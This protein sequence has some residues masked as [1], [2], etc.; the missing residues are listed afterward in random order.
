MLYRL[1]IGCL[2]IT[3][4]ATTFGADAFFLCGPDEDGC[5]AEYYSSCLCMP[6]DAQ[7]QH[8]PYCLDF[9]QVAC[10]PLAQQPGCPRAHQFPDQASCVATAFQSEPEPP[11]ERTTGD[12]CREHRVPI[13]GVDG[14]LASCH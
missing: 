9:D 2:L 12:F 4:T 1:L 8:Q 7:G 13:C 6:V 5:S 14:G 11:C 10:V 3:S